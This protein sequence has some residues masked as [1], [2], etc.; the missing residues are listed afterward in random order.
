MSKRYV[1][2][3]ELA[4]TKD[5]PGRYPVNPSTIWRWVA[6]GA[7]P[8]PYRFG[9]LCAWAEDELDEHDRAAATRPGIKPMS[10]LGNASVTARRS[11]A[12]A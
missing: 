8:K 2:L 7:F 9:D 5:R 11:K 12:S 6:S 10:R 1:R 4:S 3:R